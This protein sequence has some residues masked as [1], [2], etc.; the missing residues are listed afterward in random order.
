MPRGK[1]EINNEFLRRLW[2]DANVRTLNRYLNDALP[3][4]IAANEV[5]VDDDHLIEAGYIREPPKFRVRIGN[6]LI[7]AQPA[8]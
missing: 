7:Y 6:F 2:D 4:H 3:S 5:V 8:L 1:A